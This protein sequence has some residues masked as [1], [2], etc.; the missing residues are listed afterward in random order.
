[1]NHD[2]EN[3]FDPVPL[4]LACGLSLIAICVLGLAFA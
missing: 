2:P 3:D 4:A 1:M